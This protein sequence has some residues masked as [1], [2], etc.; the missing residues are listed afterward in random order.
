MRVKWPP[1]ERFFPFQLL[2]IFETAL[3]LSAN[4]Y[5]TTADSESGYPNNKLGKHLDCIQTTPCTGF[6]NLLLHQIRKF[7]SYESLFPTLI[8]IQKHKELTSCCEPVPGYVL[9]KELYHQH[10]VR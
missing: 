7:H 2:D 6:R 3:A 1:V 9:R 4:P 10:I 5:L 8:T